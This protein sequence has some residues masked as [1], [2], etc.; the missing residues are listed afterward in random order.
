MRWR[1]NEVGIEMDNTSPPDRL[2]VFRKL[3]KR[4]T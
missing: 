1:K 4:R 3:R 2:A